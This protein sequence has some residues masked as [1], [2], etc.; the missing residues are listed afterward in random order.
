MIQSFVEVVDM[1]SNDLGSD[2]RHSIESL[3]FSVTII[4]P[5]SRPEVIVFVCDD[6]CRGVIDEVVVTIYDCRASIVIS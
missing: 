1:T 4:V 3:M 5:S 2:H 6:L